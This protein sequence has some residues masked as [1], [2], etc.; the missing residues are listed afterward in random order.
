MLMLIK[1]QWSLRA[2]WDARG[3]R[4]H[5][6]EWVRFCPFRVMQNEW[7]VLEHLHCLRLMLYP[8]IAVELPIA[9]VPASVAVG[10]HVPSSA[11]A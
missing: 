9:A 7:S 5:T 3:A 6:R 1:R 2:T 8:P 10:A 11:D 4:G